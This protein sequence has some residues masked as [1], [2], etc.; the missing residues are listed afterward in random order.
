MN[1][2]SLLLLAALAVGASSHAALT[3]TYTNPTGTVGANDAVEIWLTLS[4]DTDVTYDPNDPDGDMTYGG[5]VAP[6]DFPTGGFAPDA[7]MGAGDF[8]EFDFVEFVGSSLFATCAGSFVVDEDGCGFAMGGTNDYSF[9]FG[10]GWDPGNNGL[11]LAA[12]ESIDFLF[13]TFTPVAGG[14]AE[15]T[16]D[17]FDSGISLFIAGFGFDDLGVEVQIDTIFDLAIA[18]ESGDPSCRFSRTVTASPVPVP[19]AFWLLASALFGVAG[20]NRRARGVNLD[21]RRST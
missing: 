13:G 5:I 17:F 3:L 7:N 16:Y 6:G 14:A 8:V 18:C 21:E 1:I 12:G 15:G 19:A 11:T 10:P 20:I 4:S 2:K 9:S